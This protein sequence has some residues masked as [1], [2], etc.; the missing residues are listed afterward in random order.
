MVATAEQINSLMESQMQE[1]TDP[2]VHDALKS[3]LVKPFLQARKWDNDDISYACWVVADDPKSNTRYVYCEEAF[4]PVIPWGI[5][6]ISGFEMG[7]D[8]GWF[9]SLERA[10]YDSFASFPL[11]IWNVVK[12]DSSGEDGIAAR[13]LTFDEADALLN[14]LNA[15]Q[16]IPTGYWIT[17]AIEPRTQKWW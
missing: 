14:K 10:F 8:S 3:L 9:Q 11:P 5:V 6:S 4:G 7:M 1:I 12:R 15:E 17:Y 16:N 2:V 13:S